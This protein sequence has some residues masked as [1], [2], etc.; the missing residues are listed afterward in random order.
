MMVQPRNL[1]RFHGLRFVTSS[2]EKKEQTLKAEREMVLAEEQMKKE[3]EGKEADMNVG[4]VKEHEGDRTNRIGISASAAYQ[5]AA[6]AASYLLSHT[7]TILPFKSAQI[8]V[9]GDTPR[10]TIGRD[11]NGEV[12]SL[13]ATTDS[14]TAVVAAK[15]E[16]K[17]AVADDLSSTRLSPC[18]WFVCDDDRSATRFF[19]IQGSESL[20]SW[21]ANLLFEPT[22]FEV[23]MPRR[24][25]LCS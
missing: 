19:V 14:V 17:Q 16:V 13:M 20:A 4:D 11:E 15:E 6:S 12:A 24:V 3:N 25:F 9:N 8:V 2:L 21:Q 5:I 10:R 18:E 7:K 22:Q 23:I 1:L